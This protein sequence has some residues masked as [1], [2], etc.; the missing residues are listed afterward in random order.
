[1]S[2]VGVKVMQETEGCES[3]KLINDK[4]KTSQDLSKIKWILN[5][6]AKENYYWPNVRQQCEVLNKSINVYF[7]IVI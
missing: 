5:T 3:E 1:M 7:W 2:V 6:A 4:K